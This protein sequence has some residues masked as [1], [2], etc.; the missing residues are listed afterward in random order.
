MK[1]YMPLILLLAAGL[2]S[3]EEVI[4]VSLAGSAPVLVAEGSIL[5]DSVCSVKLTYTSGYFDTARYVPEENARV[6]LIS[7]DQRFE[8]LEY[9]G[10]GI[11]LGNIIRG[12]PGFEYTLNIS[13]GGNEYHAASF[14][15]PRP[16]LLHVAYEILDVPHFSGETIYTIKNVIID[17][18]AEDSYYLLKYHRNGKM[19]ND[20]F[21]TYNDIY[22]KAD[23]IVYSD[24]RL[25]FYSSDTVKVD[26]YAID[27]K[28]YIYFNLVN[29]VLFSSMRASTPY[30]P[31]SNFS[32][33]ILGYFMAASVDSET[34]IIR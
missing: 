34:I 8:T 13:A 22:L 25:D 21:S 17:K 16:E 10:G 29:D 15:N 23:T 5:H 24:Y 11:Y 31:S 33:N 26:L 12:K 32:G 1:K 19:L 9:Q 27:K 2:S 28:T 30:N 3:C 4:D 7:D 20:Y 18:T 6:Y 14:L